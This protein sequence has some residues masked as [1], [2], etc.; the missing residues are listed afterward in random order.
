MSERSAP[1][2]GIDTK[3]WMNR[4]VRTRNGAHTV[5]HVC[6]DAILIVHPPVLYQFNASKGGR[7]GR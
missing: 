1:D 4:A 7:N 6:A 3:V 2:L 5:P